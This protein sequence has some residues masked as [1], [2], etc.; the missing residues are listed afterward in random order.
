MNLSIRKS[1]LS[2]HVSP[3]APEEGE[4]FQRVTSLCRHAKALQSC[5]TR[6]DL[7]DCSH[8]ASL[9]MGFSRQEHWS[10]LTFKRFFFSVNVET[11]KIF[12]S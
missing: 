6:C 9:S 12:T 5:P 11:L 7:M 2:L 10:G 1:A 3:A 4:R 8:Q